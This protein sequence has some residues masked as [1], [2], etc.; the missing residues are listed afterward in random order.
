MRVV[1]LTTGWE[2]YV[3]WQRHPKV[4]KQLNAL[5]R[6]CARDPFGG[7]GKPEPLRHELSGWWSRR[8][9]QEH[10][11]VYRVRDDDLVILQCRSHY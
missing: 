2:D 3:E 5:I 6:E 1:F 4:L 10:R 8:I 7:E 11:L 9:T